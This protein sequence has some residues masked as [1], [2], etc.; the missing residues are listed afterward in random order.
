MQAFHRYFALETHLQYPFVID[1]AEKIGVS[2]DGQGSVW[3]S[4]DE[5]R[6]LKATIL[7]TDIK[8]L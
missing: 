3:E 4:S 8:N 1:Q 6:N 2:Q 5:W 7:I